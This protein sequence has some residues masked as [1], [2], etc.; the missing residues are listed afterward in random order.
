MLGLGY[1]QNGDPPPRLPPGTK[2][3]E[4]LPPPPTFPRER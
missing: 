4:R 3:K 2:L 1:L